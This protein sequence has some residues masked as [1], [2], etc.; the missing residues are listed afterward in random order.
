[1]P[2]KA[3][4]WENWL[5]NEFIENFSYCFKDIDIFNM[6]EVYLKSYKKRRNITKEQYIRKGK[7]CIAFLVGRVDI[8]S[9]KSLATQIDIF[10]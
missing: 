1:M 7:L 10:L 3:E 2:R 4:I 9:I 6:G 8:W 5:K